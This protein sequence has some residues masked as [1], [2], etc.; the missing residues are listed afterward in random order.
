[1]KEINRSAAFDTV[2][3]NIL[4]T[5][6]HDSFG[7]SGTALE[8]FKSYLSNRTQFVRVNDSSSTSHDLNFGVPQGSVLGPFLYSLYTSPLGKIARHHEMSHY[9]YADDTPLYITF[10]RSS[11]SD[12]TQ[13]KAKLINCVKDI[14]A[15]MLSNKLRLNKD[16]SEILVISSIHHPRPSVSSVHI[17][18]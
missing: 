15:W 11:V 1:M 5:R 3:H 9:F 13:S 18:S 4:L 8:W 17:C 6:L 16:K 7:I 12:I 2:D 10:R 14:D